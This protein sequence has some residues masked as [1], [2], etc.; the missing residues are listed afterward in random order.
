MSFRA[1]AIWSLIYVVIALLFGVGLG[2]VAGWDLGTQFLA[3]YVVERSLS[4][5]NLF[6][7]VI[8]LSTF[9]VPAEYQGRALAIGIALA[10]VLR[11]IFIALGA[12]LLSAFSFMFLVFGLALIATAVQLF[13]HRDE[14]PSVSDNAV[15]AFARRRLPLTDRYDGSR[16][17]TRVDGRRML[18][19]LFIVLI[20]IGTTDFLFALDSIPAVYGVT[21]HPYIVLAANVFALVGL[22]P[23]FFLVAGLLDRLVYL[24]TG[25]S[26]ILT[27]IGAKLVLHFAHLQH[28]SIPEISTGASLAVVVVVLAVTTIASLARVRRQPSLRAHAGS[29]H[30]R[31]GEADRAARAEATRAP[32]GKAQATDTR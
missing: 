12:A 23:L 3:G 18:T 25:L 8:I 19:P 4:V 5:D 9:A 30:P 15:V 21:T 31:H 20:A 22:R 16:I 7:F 17:V 27:F 13:R 32:R 28:H 26:V 11:A 24:S 6:V 14:D 1:A 29:L 2:L 10:L